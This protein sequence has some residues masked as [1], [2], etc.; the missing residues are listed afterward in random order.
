MSES[1]K[2]KAPP[3]LELGSFIADPKSDVKTA[4]ADVFIEDS[5]SAFKARDHFISS[6]EVLSA[7]LAQFTNHSFHKD[8]KLSPAQQTINL[9]NFQ[10]LMSS[11]A[12]RVTASPNLSESEFRKK[13]EELSALYAAFALKQ[14]NLAEKKRKKV[15]Q[16]ISEFLKS[17]FLKD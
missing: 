7:S 4:P 17:I 16:R 9:A 10:Y 8:Q 6:E 2:A 11:S 1:N 14:A 5:V 13:R 3:S 15:W 12:L